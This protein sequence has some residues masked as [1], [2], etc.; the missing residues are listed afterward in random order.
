MRAVI[1]RRETAFGGTGLPL[2]A[3][4]MGPTGS[5][6]GGL[7]EELRPGAGD[8]PGVLHPLGS[9]LHRSPDVPWK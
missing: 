4:T 9:L 3:Q 7:G 1:P 2:P 5:R 6:S 8:S